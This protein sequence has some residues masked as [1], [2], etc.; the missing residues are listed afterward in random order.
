MLIKSLL[1][2]AGCHTGVK[3][4]GLSSDVRNLGSINQPFLLAFTIQRTLDWSPLAITPRAIT[5]LILSFD[6]GIVSIYHLAEIRHAAVRHFDSVPIENFPQGVIWGEGG[7]HYFKEI[8]SNSGF[9]VEGP[10][11]VKP[12]DIFISISFSF[13]SITAAAC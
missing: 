3:F 7:F 6:F 12:D 9:T 1:E 10:R 2:P 13:A 8:S 11:W 5:Y 4:A